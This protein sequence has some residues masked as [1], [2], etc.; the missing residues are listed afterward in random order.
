M[1]RTA[2]EAIEDAAPVVRTSAGAVRGAWAY[3]GGLSGETVARVAAF[4]GIPYAEPPVGPLRFA[5]PQPRSPWEGSLDATA[6]GPTPQRGDAG[7]TLIPEPSI[8]GDDTLSVNIWTP[9]P[10][11]AAALPVVVWIHG[12]GFIS[13]SPTSPWYDGGAFARDGTVLVTL[14]YRLGFT[15]FGWIEGATP[16]RGV[17]D[18]ICAL[19]WV[20]DHIGAFGGDPGR[21]TIAGQSAGGSA[22]LTLL[23]APGAAGLFHGAYAMSAAVADPSVEEARARGRRLARLAGVAP[24]LA[25]FSAVPEA[26]ILELQPRVTAPAAPRLLRELHGLIRDGLMIGPVADGE[27]VPG[28]A[29]ASAANGP[30]A[31]LPLVLG[32]ADDELMGLFP[33]RRR[34][35]RYTTDAVFRGWVPRIAAARS[36]S[37]QAGPTWSYRFAWRPDDPPRAGHCIDVPFVFDRLDA[38]GVERVA[39]ASPPQ[40]LADAVHGALV[41]LAK[42]GEPGW[43]PDDGGRGPSR[44]FDRPV[45]DEPNAYASVARSELRRRAPAGYARPRST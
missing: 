22:V 7:I 33:R 23:G 18:W 30:S 27:I 12:G 9:D 32:T 14:S 45:R 26:R 39:G 5:P 24:N 17:L 42:T 31:G 20:R 37:P 25:G 40:E 10:D 29:V 2:A 1:S 36:D 34:L 43:A 16:N 4:R 38:P 8:P 28:G 35:G 21:V 11:P 15:G 13:G 3:P 6:F 44:V 41:A 19:R